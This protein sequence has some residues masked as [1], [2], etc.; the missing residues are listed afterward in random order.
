MKPISLRMQAFGPYAG[1][2]EVDFVRLSEVGLFVVSGPTGAGKT[3][4]F[5]AMAYALFGDLPGERSGFNELRSDHAALD[6]LCE[7]EFHFDAAGSRWR[8]NRIPTQERAKKRGTGTA[9]ELAKASLDR[10][11][12][13]EW[14]PVS[15][16]VRDVSERCSDLIGLNADQF[17]RVVLLPQGQFQQV[18]KAKSAERRELLRTLFSSSLYSQIELRLKERASVAESVL[19]D[20]GRQQGSDHEVARTALLE[21]ARVLEVD[22]PLLDNNSTLEELDAVSA[23]LADPVLSDRRELLTRREAA[24]RDAAAGREKAEGQARALE[25]LEM[26]GTRQVFL[27]GQAEQFAATRH[28]IEQAERARPLAKTAES[29]HAH[30]A[31]AADARDGALRLTEQLVTRGA[32]VGLVTAGVVVGDVPTSEVVSEI[33]SQAGAVAEATR[34]A[35]E[36]L[37]SAQAAQAAAK[38]AAA[39]CIQESENL[40]AYEKRRSDLDQQQV[41]RRV[42]V[43]SLEVAAAGI[44]RKV[45]DHTAA[46]A[47]LTLARRL[48]AL[49]KRAAEVEA[50]AASQV[51]TQEEALSR[52]DALDPVIEACRLRADALDSR[53]QRVADLQSVLVRR[54]RLSEAQLAVVALGKRSLAASER[55][56]ATLR[57]FE[58]AASPRLAR[59]LVDGEPCAVC[60]SLSHPAPATA[61]SDDSEMADLAAVEQTHT[62]ASGLVRQLGQTTATVDSLT[63][64]LGDHVSVE[65]NELNEQIAAAEASIADAK[66]AKRQLV[67]SQT[68][69]VDLRTRLERAG[70]LLVGINE[71]LRTVQSERAHV[72]GALGDD[73]SLPIDD[74]ADKVAAADALVAEARSS[75][76]RLDT[77]NAEIRQ[78]DEAL[79]QCAADIV[80]SQQAKAKHEQTEDLETTR[81]DEILD[82]IEG[83]L[84]DYTKRGLLINEFLAAVGRVDH[85]LRVVAEHEARREALSVA[86]SEQ[87]GESDFPSI[88][89]ALQS[90]L[91]LAHQRQLQ[92]SFDEWETKSADVAAA[93]EEVRQVPLP[94]EAPDLPALIAAEQAANA[95]E[96]LVRAQVTA[97]DLHLA[98]A[99]ERLAKIRILEGEVAETRA[100]A[101]RIKE[102]ADVCAGNGPTR[103]SLESWVLAAHL[104]DVVELANKHLAPMSSG[105]YELVVADAPDDRRREAGLDLTVL[106]ARSGKAR[107]V[108]SLSGGETFQASLALALGLADVVSANRGGVQIDALFVDEGFGSLDAESLDHAIDVLD[109]LR[110]RGSLV[111]VITHV[112]AMKQ[113]LQVGI[114]VERDPTGNGSRLTQ[115][116]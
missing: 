71:E 34:R 41:Q 50:N 12:D 83:S 19:D 3:S 97:A 93:I 55:A 14:V 11:D 91:E 84:D 53:T 23:A 48:D 81:A 63:E 57:R 66:K 30:A 112:E 43:A 113:A 56:T 36:R 33:R 115:L 107:P 74:L 29:V 26:L 82:G 92:A 32:G 18:L 114:V 87:L 101:Q 52:L 42:A 76:E 8:V 88:D 10:L 89:V 46:A 47:G 2:A 116:V 7:V 111:G 54:G 62:D 40:V 80:R 72:E 65:I 70:A 25:R 17:Q 24:V 110:S 98:Q 31:Q 104:R 59:S 58:R 27:A 28:R 22:E 21:T 78:T 9:K 109:G 106:D 100:G 85:A 99:A 68:E 77:V 61:D 73:A 1:T 79:S 105:R 15:S 60:G 49:V 5:D 103:R 90:V 94:E 96:H 16:S 35:T 6:V 102:L 44:E 20:L 51:T 95:N 75:V 64:G 37:A 69:Q 45:T 39:A 108:A 4:I 86:L 13:G 67:E 38:A